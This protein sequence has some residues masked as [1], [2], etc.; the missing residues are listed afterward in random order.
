MLEL[1][2]SDS[3][4][5]G[6][7]LPTLSFSCKGNLM[8]I[9]AWSSSFLSKA[10]CLKKRVWEIL[11]A[12]VLV[13]YPLSAHALP[14]PFMLFGFF[15]ISL[16]VVGLLSGGV[17]VVGLVLLRLVYK[18]KNPVRFLLIISSLFALLWL[19]TLTL[20]MVNWSGKSKVN[21]L[22]NLEAYM[23]SDIGIHESRVWFCKFIERYPEA[24]LD[25]LDA[26]M[27]ADPEY[28]PL[29]IVSCSKVCYDS[30]IP[31]VGSVQKRHLFERVD[32]ANL[33]T[34]LTNIPL[35]KR[36]Q[37]DLYWLPL[38]LFYRAQPPEK[39][40]TLHELLSTFRQVFYVKPQSG[41]SHYKF[42]RMPNDTLVPALYTSPRKRTYWPVRPDTYFHDESHIL[43][44]NMTKVFSARDLK[45]H[46]ANP[47]IPIVAPY[48]GIHR[49]RTIHHEYLSVYFLPRLGPI[50][51]RQYFE[52]PEHQKQV[53][54]RMQRKNIYTFDYTA[55]DYEEQAKRLSAELSNKPFLVV[56]LSKHDWL[57]GGMDFCYRMYHDSL[58]QQKSF[59]YLG[60]TLQVAEY[61]TDR[62]WKE[63]LVLRIKQP[64]KLIQKKI[65]PMV[66]RLTKTITPF[67]DLIL[68][69]L[70]LLLFIM[71][72]PA[73]APGLWA[74]RVRQQLTHSLQASQAEHPYRINLK[75]LFLNNLGYHPLLEIVEKSTSLILL[76]VCF[77]LLIFPDNPLLKNQGFFIAALDKPHPWLNLFLVLIALIPLLPK[78]LSTLKQPGPGGKFLAATVLSVGFFLLLNLLVPAAYV[79]FI[80]SFFLLRLLTSLI[81]HSL[82]Q[83]Q[84]SE[85]LDF[86]TNTVPETKLHFPDHMVPLTLDSLSQ[87]PDKAATL[88]KCSALQQ[89]L[90][91]VPPGFVLFPKRLPNTSE[92]EYAEHLLR[93]VELYFP[94]AASHSYAVRSC[95][96]TEDGQR[97][98]QAGRFSSMVNVSLSDLV[99][100]VTHVLDSYRKENVPVDNSTGVII[101][102]MIDAEISGV[103]FTQSPRSGALSQLEYVL[104]KAES[105]VSGSKQPEEI[106]FS[107]WS[108]AH[109]PSP[110]K[111][112]SELQTVFLSGMLLEKTLSAPQD[113]EWVYCKRDRK[114]YLV[115][116]RPITRFVFSQDLYS[117]QT[118]FLSAGLGKP[119]ARQT[120]TN[121]EI[122]PLHEV[123]ETPR[124]FT[125]SL[126]QQLY[127]SQGS[128]GL[129]LDRLHITHRFVP[130]LEVVSF[131][132]RLYV[133]RPGL[134]QL[135]ARMRYWLSSRFAAQH[136]RRNPARALKDLR[137][138]LN[139]VK[140]LVLS[141]T[142][143]TTTSALA[144]EAQ[145]QLRLFITKV[146]PV[147]FQASV[148]CSLLPL[149]RTQQRHPFTK[150]S[151]LAQ[152]LHQLSHD[153]NVEAF[154][155]SWGFR[156]VQDYDLFFPS[157]QEDPSSAQ[158]LARRFE[159]LA[160][161]TTAASDESNHFLQLL[162]AKEEIK[163]Y[164]IQW[165]RQ[166]RPLFLALGQTLG[167][168]SPTDIFY[169][170]LSDL[171]LISDKKPL[172][173]LLKIVEQNKKRWQA[174][175]EISLPDHLTLS[176]VEFLNPQALL[177]ST[178]LHA[179]TTNNKTPDLFGQHLSL[180]QDFSGEVL[181][182]NQAFDQAPDFYQD[183]VLVTRFLK[184][185]LVSVY[186]TVAGIITELGGYLSHAALVAR[187][188]GVPVLQV[189]DCCARLTE[190][191]SVQVKTNGD[192]F[193]LHN[194]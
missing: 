123:V 113:I 170:S 79:F 53:L 142:L 95:A 57:M 89:S 110:A 135:S 69:L 99:P 126:L 115:Q 194:N 21:Y 129:A 44:P 158:A 183:K 81:V 116:S 73:I 71:L 2:Y 85:L 96:A 171:D 19:I 175:A 7:M 45:K 3:A 12:G 182:V 150:A 39:H 112:L 108:G 80:L 78:P 9:I 134:R 162:Q 144:V 58:S 179:L 119:F 6:W 97:E 178:P 49:N 138:Q 185:E 188:K 148:L 61:V 17:A 191:D 154:L 4:S 151:A 100:A 130:G 87:L 68:M 76:L 75:P 52:N 177:P 98:S 15:E 101:Q 28:R 103:L 74:Q 137:G 47:T 64:L 114:L 184:P 180:P 42:K 84:I 192:L 153:Q 161:T 46:L 56:A 173:D 187:E 50:N 22:N 31:G 77:E 117:E 145:K 11:L 193:L 82:A 131:Y 181:K 143:P 10:A 13:F 27:S 26:K 156:S 23:R 32:L 86:K 124:P 1:Y 20:L 43:F 105:L 38:Q 186:G 34:Y 30:G 70:A 168:S 5:A 18:R 163:D 62:I 16:L 167:L 190:G 120:V 104:G 166:R 66:N 189:R 54:L 14:A 140:S 106:Y 48:N 25:A 146:Y 60:A 133:E 102:K 136:V 40:K 159:R 107:R 24:S 65:V 90:F 109:T 157:F 37:L 125:L 91:T 118:R 160:K 41:I 83:R 172:T 127:C 63:T 93:A 8:R 55:S 152:A 149:K 155:T 132:N 72:S 121:W 59:H 92:K 169:L 35:K 141:E 147:A 111:V 165:L 29:M 164:V 176:D 139:E 122:S 67:A 128:L 174:M 36:E 33:E 88:A 51:L 94:N